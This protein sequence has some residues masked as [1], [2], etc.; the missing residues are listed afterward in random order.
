MSTYVTAFRLTGA[1]K[2]KGQQIHNIVETVVSEC[3][4]LS[5]H[6]DMQLFLTELEFGLMQYPSPGHAPGTLDSTGF[7]A[8]SMT[9][10]WIDNPNDIMWI[11]PEPSDSLFLVQMAIHVEHHY[12][13]L[14]FYGTFDQ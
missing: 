14:E 9:A 6:Q 1:N 12:M 13:K 8:S 3:I 11:L 5:R 10:S 2:P 4:N 7:S